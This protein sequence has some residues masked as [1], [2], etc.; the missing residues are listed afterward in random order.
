MAIQRRVIAA[1]LVAAAMVV[2][3]C[4][5]NGPTRP[6][7]ISSPPPPAAASVVRVEVEAPASMDP[8]ASLQLKAN[9]IKSDGSAENVTAQAQWSS[10][11]TGVVE[12]SAA[13]VAT[14]RARGEANVI[15]RYQSRSASARLLVLPAGTFRLTGQVADGSVALSGVTVTVLAGTGEGLSAVSDMTGA[16]AIYGVGGRVRIQAKKE[17]YDNALAD[18][19]VSNHVRLDLNLRFS[20]QRPD[21]NGSYTLTIEAVVCSGFAGAPLPEEARRRSYRATLNQDGANLEVRLSGA[22]FIVTNGHGDRFGGIISGDTVTFA[23]G[24]AYY[25]YSYYSGHFGLIERLSSSGA[26]LV[27]GTVSAKADSSGID[28]TLRGSVLISRGTTPPF[29]QFSNGCFSSAHRFEMRRD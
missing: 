1:M 27:N 23:V 19:D 20:G 24:D 13:G 5:D 3:S 25:Y 15:A 9:A 2:M 17:G 21:L 12:V 16:Y 14:A 8:D 4:G 28:G 29:T 6:A 10:S 26:F 11:N 7:P 22:D 18:L